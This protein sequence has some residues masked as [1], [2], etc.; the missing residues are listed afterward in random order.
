[1]VKQQTADR[2]ANPDY[3]DAPFISNH[4][5]TRISAQCVNNEE[6]MKFAAGIDDDDAGQSLWFIT[7]KSWG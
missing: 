3:I 2:L 6:Q 1:M 7:E 4:D 5:T